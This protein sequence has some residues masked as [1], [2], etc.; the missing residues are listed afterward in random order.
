MSAGELPAAATRCVQVRISGRVQGVGFRAW[1]ERR[2]RELG[3]SGWVRN[4]PGG[5][6][7]AVF[8]G[9]AAEVEAMLAA[10]REGPRPA[11]VERVDAKDAEDGPSGSFTMRF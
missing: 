2:A 5:D 9:P 11:V 6:V 3:I 8:R 10:C 1:T 7:E 4:L